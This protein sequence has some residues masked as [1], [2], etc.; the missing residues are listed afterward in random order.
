MQVTATKARRERVAPGSWTFGLT[1][2]EAVSACKQKSLELYQWIDG[3]TLPSPSKC[4]PGSWVPNASASVEP[5][6][7]RISSIALVGDGFG[8][9][10]LVSFAGAQQDSFV[11]E[12]RDRYELRPGRGMSC[13]LGHLTRPSVSN[14]SIG[15]LMK[16]AMDAQR[17]VGVSL[18][19]K[20]FQSLII[21][22][23]VLSQC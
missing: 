2:E 22:R 5:A 1:G 3:G 13:V 8:L 16:D 18:F 7:L 12:G 17:G 14:V 9:F 21:L 11:D 10:C 15:L 4:L 19:D 23:P 6:P 20:S